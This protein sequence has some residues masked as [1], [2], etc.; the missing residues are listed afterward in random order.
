MS[1]SWTLFLLDMCDAGEKILRYTDGMRF[2]DFRSNQLVSDAVLRNL[3]LI[4][5]AAKGITPDIRQ[6]YAE[7]DW[8]GMAGLRDIL[9]HAYF[10]ID[11]VT[12]WEIV[13]QRVPELLAGLRRIRDAE[14]L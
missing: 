1:R 3:E 11:D 7:V 13:S 14:N 8:R 4:G 10:A 9:A 6:R 2:E 5:E 12:L